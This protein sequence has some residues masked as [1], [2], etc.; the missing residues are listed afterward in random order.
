MPPAAAPAQ[1]AHG[2]GLSTALCPALCSGGEGGTWLLPSPGDPSWEVLQ[3]LP[4]RAYPPEQLRLPVLGVGTS[5]ASMVPA[6]I[7]QGA[8][9]PAEASL[10]CISQHRKLPA[11]LLSFLPEILGP[12]QPVQHD[13]ELTVTIATEEGLGLL[14]VQFNSSLTVPQGRERPFPHTP[15][16]P[17]SPNTNCLPLCLLLLSWGLLCAAHPKP[18]P[19]NQ[20]LTAVLKETHNCHRL[21]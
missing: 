10:G 18:C 16:L 5:T 6:S 12:S 1:L 17:V 2:R 13:W 21:P 9:K 7:H 8:V 14:T 11:A 3:C 19:H 4:S 15:P 20:P